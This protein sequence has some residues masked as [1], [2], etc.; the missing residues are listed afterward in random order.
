MPI[1]GQNPF[2]PEFFALAKEG[3]PLYPMD[4]VTPTR[5]A[6]RAV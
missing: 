5:V 6:P 1:V 2:G 3:A 4:D